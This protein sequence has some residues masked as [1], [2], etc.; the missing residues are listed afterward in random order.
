[1]QSEKQLDVVAKWTIMINHYEN[2]KGFL[3][4][5]GSPHALGEKHTVFLSHHDVVSTVTMLSVEAD[6]EIPP[7]GIGFTGKRIT[8][9]PT[10]LP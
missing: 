8:V 5:G 3:L 7:T 4:Y 2:T 6:A 10:R 1:V 9:G